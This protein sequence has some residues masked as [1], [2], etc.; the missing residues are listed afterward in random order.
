M[1]SE[2]GRR[3]VV[4]LAFV[5]AA[6]AAPVARAQNEDPSAVAARVH[7]EGGY[8]EDIVLFD[9]GDDSPSAGGAGE[10]DGA[11]DGP[12]GLV[13]PG[14]RDGGEPNQGLDIPMP[15]FLRDLL[16][17]LSSLV[18]AAAMPIAYLAF[19]LGIAVVIG[20]VVYMFA[21]LR[22]RPP[23]LASRKRERQAVD[24]PLLD[25]LLEEALL[26]H[27]E[28]A[29]NGRYR[30]AIH[31]VFLGSLSRALRTTD[32]DRRGRTAREVV[33]LT[34]RA[35]G[36][37]GLADLLSLTELVWFGGRP[38]TVDQYELAK[39]LASRVTAPVAVAVAP[40]EERAP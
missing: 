16:R 40:S 14:E 35:S 19:A 6:L 17:A 39:A 33:G 27:E 37:E 7:R 4:G 15:P 20:F 5:C 21:Y 25:P 13:H 23:E 38:A 34:A 8:P 24:A 18:G 28:Y 3:F 9:D 22:L 11:G 12:H 36:H 26:S 31:A 10:D 32:V 1:H 30:E 29:A 2:R